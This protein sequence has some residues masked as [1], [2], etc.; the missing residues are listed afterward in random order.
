MATLPNSS[1]KPSRTTASSRNWVAAAGASCKAEDVNLHRCQIAQ[2]ELIVRVYWARQPRA[3]GA[4]IPLYK[5]FLLAFVMFVHFATEASS[6]V[7]PT[8]SFEAIAKRIE[9]GDVNALGL[10]A[11]SRN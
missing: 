11:N 7:A 2:P 5:L 1:A 6:Q 3:S 4:Y 10:A 8:E 9:A